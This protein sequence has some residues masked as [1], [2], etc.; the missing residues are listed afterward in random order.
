MTEPAASGGRQAARSSLLG[1]WAMHEPAFLDVAQRVRLPEPFADRPLGGQLAN[2]RLV[3][4]ANDGPGYELL[5]GGIARIDIVDT[6]TK[7]GAW[8]TDNPGMV[9]LRR[10]VRAAADAASVRG[11]L[12]RVDSPGGTVAGTADLADEVAA[13]AAVKPVVGYVEDLGASCA[14]W[15]AA[16]SD[17]L[18]ANSTAIVG[19]IGVYG[20]LYDYSKMFSKEG[21][22][23]VVIR[24]GKFKAIGTPGAPITEEQTTELQRT[25]DAIHIRFV[26]AVARGRNLVPAFVS[27]ELADGAV[28]VGAE[29]VERRLVDEVGTLD[30]AYADLLTRVTDASRGNRDQA[31]RGSRVTSS[32]PRESLDMDQKEVDKLT[33][34]A[35]ATAGDEAR[36]AERDRLTALKAAFADDAEFAMAAFEKGHDVTRAKA[37]YCDVLAERCAKQT[38]ENAEL[39]KK[40]GAATKAQAKPGVEGVSEGGGSA[41]GGEDPEAAGN[42]AVAAERAAGRTPQEAVRRVAAAQPELRAAYVESYNAARP[43]N[44]A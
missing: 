23:A 29:A 4:G 33:A 26:G 8:W 39:I 11:I 17:A 35:G 6:L 14:Y 25:T 38:T 37:E 24:S 19:S 31:P 32:G 44:R 36:K 1:V 34:A 9:E 5:E 41:S 27:D 10:T 3:A 28:Y 16:Q 7:Y 18:W 43:R 21:V 42:A 30:A 13:A 20:V 12:L 2:A 22:R 15:I 40:Q